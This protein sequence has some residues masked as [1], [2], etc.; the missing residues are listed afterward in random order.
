[1]KPTCILALSFLAQISYGQLPPV[2][3]GNISIEVQQVVSGLSSPVEMV[4]AND[5]TNRLFIVEQPGRIRIL[6]NGALNAAPFLDMTAQVQSGGERGFLGLA[7]H[8]GFANPASGGFRK[9]YTFATET[10]SVAADFTVPMMGAFAS[11]IVIAEWQV[12]DA[13]PNVA[14]PSSR[15]VLLRIDHPQANHNAGKIAFRPSDGYLYIA[16]GDGGNANDVGD[17]H[18]AI[19]GNAQDKTNLLGKILRIDPLVPFANPASADPI[20]NNGRYRIAN[21]NPFFGASGLREIYAY[22][23]RNPYRF[24]FDGQSD[25]L[26][27]GDVGQ[28]SIEEV[29]LVLIG[30]NYGWHRRE[31]T[32][33]FNS[34]T[35]GVSIDPDIDLTLTNPALEYDH[36]DGTSVIGGFVYRGS[37]IPALAAK[38]VFGDFSSPAT[39]SGRLFYEGSTAGSIKEFRLGINSR[40]LGLVIKGFGE[41]LEHELYVMAENAN[42]T[43]GQILKIV[44]IPATPALINLSTRA[45]I[46]SDDEGSAIAGFIITGSAAKTV[47]LRGIGPSLA[48]AGLPVPGRL[49]NPT[50]SLRDVR[51]QEL[52]ANDDWMNTAR[53]QDLINFGLAPT[54][55]SESAIVATLLPGAYT[56]IM[57][58]AGGATGIGLVELFDVTSGVPANAVNLSTRARVQT[59]DNVL[60]GGLIIGGT[61]TQRVILRAIGPSLAAQ[62]VT[63]ELHDPTLELVDSSGARLAFNDNWRSDQASE[64]MATGLAPANDAESAIVR[65]LA[66]GSYTAIVRGAGDTSGV[67]LVEAFR[68]SP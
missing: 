61:Q 45:R 67:A 25:E 6:Q 31:G 3:T 48:T 34:V 62:G 5:G 64:I 51:G 27:V 44:P 26:I 39:G 37:A 24:S 58:G 66:P 50:L 55:P 19:I 22:G 38:Y 47:V 46:E 28:N 56:A 49:S 20:S 52:D 65:T 18:T 30:R 63:G 17:G 59:G 7:F 40:A 8:P 12:S 60:I 35:G 16:M 54:D 11:Q 14:D 32:F 36:D 41:D 2:P 43:A 15:R 21:S 23:F 68:L 42:N 57:Q 4:S 13:N 29:D 53:R 1:M 10:P 33:L 9:F